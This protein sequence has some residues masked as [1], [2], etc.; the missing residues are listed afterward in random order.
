MGHSITFFYLG[1]FSLQCLATFLPLWEF[2]LMI[3]YYGENS[4]NTLYRFTLHINK[5]FQSINQLIRNDFV[6]TMLKYSSQRKY[7]AGCFRTTYL[8]LFGL[9]KIKIKTINFTLDVSSLSKP[10]VVYSD[11]VNLLSLSH[12]SELGKEAICKSTPHGI[13]LSWRRVL[14]ASRN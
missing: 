12:S 6:C 10:W 1:F 4:V 14:S 11:N 8:I 5:P 3:G 9:F 13:P 2:W 7:T